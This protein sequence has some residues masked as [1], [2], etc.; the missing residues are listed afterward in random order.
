LDPHEDDGVSEEVLADALIL[1]ATRVVLF[2]DKLVGVLRVCLINFSETSG[3]S[4]TSSAGSLREAAR[5][6]L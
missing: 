1:D 3:T 5:Q 4:G 2:N 6:S